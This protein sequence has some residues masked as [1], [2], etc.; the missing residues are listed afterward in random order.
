MRMASSDRSVHLIGVSS[1]GFEEQR[2]CQTEKHCGIMACALAHPR[3]A[4]LPAANRRK[5]AG[6]RRWSAC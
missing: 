5:V 4:L 1:R 2:K 3:S 6:Q